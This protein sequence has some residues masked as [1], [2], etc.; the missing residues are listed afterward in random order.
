MNDNI[1]CIFLNARGD[2]GGFTEEQR[3][4][5]EYIAGNAVEDDLCFEI[6]EKVGELKYNK[7]IRREFM[8]LEDMKDEARRM[9]YEEGRQDG[10]GQGIEQERRNTVLRMHED[11]LSIELISRYT[12]VSP[13]EAKKIIA[14]LP[15]A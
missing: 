14:E 1:R 13:E 7:T 5:L 6:N 2:L 12:G 3:S 4:F 11:G 10:F 8:T 9:G 15:E